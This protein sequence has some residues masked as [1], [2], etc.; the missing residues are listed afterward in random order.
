[1]ETHSKP[2]VA[3]KW[4]QT[5]LITITPT[6]NKGHAEAISQ[7]VPELKVLR[8]NKPGACMVCELC[9]LDK[10]REISRKGKGGNE[11]RAAGG[12]SPTASPNRLK[13]NT[14]SARD[15]MPAPIPCFQFPQRLTSERACET[16]RPDY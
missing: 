9:W 13:K 1:M 7:K 12:I 8:K 10:G 5:K 6:Q 16:K 2:R 3:P 15:H 14:Q 4:R 11:R